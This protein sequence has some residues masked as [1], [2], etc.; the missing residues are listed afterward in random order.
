MSLVTFLVPAMVVENDLQLAGKVAGGPFPNTRGSPL[1][2]IVRT[3]QLAKTKTIN[4]E[5]FGGE[6]LGV[7]G[8]AVMRCRQSIVAPLRDCPN[9]PIAHDC[10]LFNNV[11]P[12]NSQNLVTLFLQICVSSAVVLFPCVRKM[13]LSINFQNQL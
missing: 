5:R 4:R 10:W 12:G 1:P 11:M 6:G 9:Y 8:F 3:M 13:M 2:R 7:R